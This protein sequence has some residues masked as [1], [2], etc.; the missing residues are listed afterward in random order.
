V[1]LLR[2]ILAFAGLPFLTLLTPFLFLPLLARVAGAEAWLAIAIGQSVGAF[3]AL[4][5]ALGYNTVGPTVVALESAARRSAVLERSIRPRLALF[6]PAVIV[7]ATIAASI[8]PEAHRLDAALMAIA[9]TLSG[10]SSSW[11]MIGLGRASLIVLYELLPRM[12]ATATAAAALLTVGQV[13]WY[14]VLLI[15]AALS[16]SGAF[17][18]F[19][20]DVR[21]LLRPQPGAMRREF[22]ANR[23]ALTTEIASGAYNSLAVAFV[24]IASPVTQA[25][26]YVSGDKLYRIGQYSV[27]ALGNAVQGWVVEENRQE[28]TQ[29]ARVSFILHLVLGLLGLA[30]FVLLGPWLSGALFGAEV[31]IDLST[32][33]AFGVATLGIA[34]GTALGRV[35]LVGLE[36]RRDFMVS[37]IIGAA[38]GIPA[39][40][41]LAS[42]F[43]A[44]GGAWGLALA[45]LVSVACQAV[46]VARRWPKPESH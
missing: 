35:I 42:T 23:S 10:L 36:A 3:A 13:T 46:F 17:V 32:A 37:V 6:V 20:V 41:I 5:V 44:A 8:A 7:A 14:P 39:V 26:S 30:A 28:F 22:V 1:G 38:V 18:Y 12:V 2:R 34:L 29:R 11:Y 33:V 25:A 15:A 43:G 9:L 16:G 24:S 31:A 19:T 27:S 21:A 4:V 40:V 45:E